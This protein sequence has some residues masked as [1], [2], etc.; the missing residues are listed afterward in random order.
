MIG[1]STITLTVQADGRNLIFFWLRTD[2]ESLTSSLRIEG[3][4]TSRLTIRNVE[5]GDTGSYICEV[6]N[7]AGSVRSTEALVT[8]SKW[9]VA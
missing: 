6:S 2:G 9:L 8:V 5:E 7:S 3:A 1:G 4:R